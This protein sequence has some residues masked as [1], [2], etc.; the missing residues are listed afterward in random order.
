[1]GFLPDKSNFTAENELREQYIAV[2]AV[3][4]LTNS[5]LPKLVRVRHCRAP[6]W[7]DPKSHGY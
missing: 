1:M 2:N 6:L 5:L 7:S 4:K 3:V